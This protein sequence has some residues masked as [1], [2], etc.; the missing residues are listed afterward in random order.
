M[1]RSESIAELAKALVK[2]QAAMTHVAKKKVAKIQTRSGGEY[3]Y[4]YADL[5]DVWDT[6]RTP[7]TDN[8]LSVSQHPH[9]ADGYLCVDTL[10]LHESGEWLLSTMRVAASDTDVRALG[11]AITYLRRYALASAIGLVSDEDTDGEGGDPPHQRA[12][13]NG[14]RPPQPT[15]R[16]TPQAYTGDPAAHVLGF[17]KYKGLTLGQIVKKDRG[18]LEWLADQGTYLDDRQRAQA[19]LD[20]ED[21]EAFA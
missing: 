21:E 2:A 12:A 20:A 4:S 6:C 11:S 18:Y 16:S 1:E 8:G 9:Y 14:S 15:A 7:L 10:L 13:T 17:G 3:S 19:V 5:A